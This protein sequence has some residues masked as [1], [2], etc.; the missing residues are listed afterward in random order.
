MYTKTDIDELLDKVSQDRNTSILKS[1]NSLEGKSVSP[2]IDL[3]D[4]NEDE[5][6]FVS[7]S[8]DKALKNNYS[9]ETN[10][11]QDQSQKIDNLLNDVINEVVY[12]KLLKTHQKLNSGDEKNFRELEKPSIKSEAII[13]E[14][15]NDNVKEDIPSFSHDW[16]EAFNLETKKSTITSLKMGSENKTHNKELE[17]SSIKSEKIIKESGNDDLKE[18]IPSSSHDW[19]EAFNLETEI[20]NKNTVDN[21][22]A[23][24]QKINEND[25]DYYYSGHSLNSF[26]V[27]SWI[28]SGN[29][30]RT[31]SDLIVMSEDEDQVIFVDYFTNHELPSIQ[32][33]NG[34]LLKGSLLSAL[35]G[36]MAPGQ[37]VQATG[38]GVLSIGEVSSVKGVAKATRL[39][40]N[41]FTLSNGDPIFKGD[42]IE[43]EG[44]GSV[45]LVFLDKTTMSL[46]EGGKMVLDELVY[47]PSTGTGSMAVDM[48]E[49][50][51]SF[52]SG[53]I[54]KTGP[55]AMS[56]ST[57]VAT[58]GIRGTTVAGKAAVEGNANSFTL[59][60]DA[61]GGV[62]QI[63]VSN[64]AGTQTLSQ[65]GATTSIASFNVAPP[66]PIILT[67]AQIQADYG[68]ALAVLPPTPV[69]APQPQ[70]APPPQEEEQQ[71]QQQE[72]A[73]E[74]EEISEETAVVEEGV[75]EEEGEAGEELA[76]EEGLGPDGESLGEGEE[77]LE[78]EESMGSEISDEENLE[79]EVAAN[80]AFESAMAD[81]ATPEEAMAAAAAEA[82][83]F[84]E[85]SND[86]SINEE[87]PGS[88]IFGDS[89]D[90]IGVNS[91]GNEF[92]DLG[93]DFGDSAGDF[94]SLGENFGGPG[95]GFGG[96]TLS[97]GFGAG[98][99]GSIA[100]TFGGAYSESPGEMFM[101]MSLPSDSYGEINT[102]FDSDIFG[103]DNFLNID[104][105]Y[106]E[107][108]DSFE[109]T[110][111]EDASLYDDFEEDIIEAD[112][113][114]DNN[115][116]VSSN[117]I[118][119]TSEA[120]N[121]Y[122][123][124]ENDIIYGH[125]GVDKI[126]G[127]NGDDTLIGGT[128]SDYLIGGEG[129]DIFYYDVDGGAIPDG[130]IIVDFEPGIDV[131]E[132]NTIPSH[133]VY[134]R[135]GFLDVTNTFDYDADANSNNIPIV[136][137]FYQHHFDNIPNQD[138]ASST[139]VSVGLNFFIKGTDYMGN[140]TISDFLIVTG[141]G[142][143][144]A[145]FLWSDTS[146]GGSFDETELSLIAILE[147]IDNDSLS[148]SDFTLSL[149]T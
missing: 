44:S 59:L 149:G 137:N 38:E 100:S 5:K 47:D 14:S 132:F 82:G 142:T 11:D 37:Y 7:K 108:S 74:D 3:K 118:S 79:S 34:L 35:A 90:N 61:G 21:H 62:G 101:S 49:G 16:K 146:M 121:I 24:I 20:T 99:F 18:D 140:G 73:S 130:D 51:F 43:T 6:F 93:G 1:L 31:Q 26:N 84:N 141:D 60:Q 29:F 57:P 102:S 110:Y 109:E 114:N 122:G 48:L 126:Y 112:E 97:G 92:E 63:S 12:N 36:P 139:E 120:E 25:L 41:I 104:Y 27:P 30:S 85:S 98:S 75:A 143:D 145:V 32:T 106:T 117:T 53:E 96:N 128:G 144:S 17:K 88:D 40:G 23:S 111:Y 64:A 58:I 42:V 123:T 72:E 69:V 66:P 94:E 39:D 147:D 86:F 116:S 4:I 87:L 133:S 28:P 129:R 33:E 78:G 46:S 105:D 52:V 95:E 103:F 55:D 13:K 81:G 10:E 127:L 131:L 136:F 22:F 107:T 83:G 8:F 68:S 89:N 80:E 77:G 2:K 19:K 54:A 45:G 76:E 71:E 50:A 65:V 134:T 113:T 56:V 124:E 119:G 135:S 125:G 115:S 15:G 91:F 9:N 70:S 138:W 67:A 148:S